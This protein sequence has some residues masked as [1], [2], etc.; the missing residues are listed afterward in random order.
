MKMLKSK[1][2]EIKEREHMEKIEDIKGVQK[3]IAWEAK[4]VRMFSTRTTL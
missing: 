2:I 1:L 3:D 4:S